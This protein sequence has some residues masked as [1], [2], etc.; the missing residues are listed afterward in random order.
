MLLGSVACGFASAAVA[1]IG[2]NNWPIVAM[3]VPTFLGFGFALWSN[4]RAAN[5]RELIE[6][7]PRAVRVTRASPIASEAIEFD[8]ARVRVGITSDF[9]V[10][11]RLTL[12]EG[13]RSLTIGA[14]LSP[15]E[16]RDLAT[17]LERSLRTRLASS[18]RTTS[19]DPS[20]TTGSF[21]HPSHRPCRSDS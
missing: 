9:Y 6:I 17:A 13:M 14:F 20:A 3:I 7:T 11:D 5:R 1:T 12:Q 16:R 19:P 15:S 8:T 10:E 18:D 21:R 4:N 2:F